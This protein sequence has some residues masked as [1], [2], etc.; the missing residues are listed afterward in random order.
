LCQSQGFV[1]SQRGRGELGQ[2]QS[3]KDIVR[4]TLKEQVVGFACSCF[5]PHPISHHVQEDWYGNSTQR[6]QRND[7][8]HACQGSR[9]KQQDGEANVEIVQG[10]R[11]AE[12]GPQQPIDGNLYLSASLEIEHESVSSRA[13]KNNQRSVPKQMDI[14][15]VAS[16][17]EISSDRADL[18]EQCESRAGTAQRAPCE[19]TREPKG[20]VL[21]H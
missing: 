13:K 20:W 10:S 19:S 11:R 9:R 7:H 6:Y 4:Q 16:P 18:P 2:E 15:R 21:C 14:G 17:W 12:K 1:S 3:D 8:S 5:K